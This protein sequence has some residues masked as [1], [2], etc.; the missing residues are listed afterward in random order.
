MDPGR[1]ADVTRHRT[2]PQGLGNI[3]IGAVKPPSRRMDRPA[4]RHLPNGKKAHLYNSDDFLS[5][6]APARP[7]R[8]HTR[9]S[10]S[11]VG[12]NLYPEEPLGPDAP[13]EPRRGWAVYRRCLGAP[14]G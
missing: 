1:S 11:E 4:R 12:P 10:S 2:Y 13:A 14:G 3:G 8:V 6:K 7:A 9:E 5:N